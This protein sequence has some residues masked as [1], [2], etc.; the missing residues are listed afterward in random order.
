MRSPRRGGQPQE[1]LTKQTSQVFPTSKV[2]I[3]L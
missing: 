3:R 1:A 2:T